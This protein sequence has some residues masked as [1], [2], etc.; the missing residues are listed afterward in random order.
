MPAVAA[1]VAGNSTSPLL[2]LLAALRLL[3][4][5][6]L[7]PLPRALLVARLL[8]LRSAKAQ[9]QLPPPPR[10]SPPPPPPPLP[11]SLTKLSYSYNATVRF[12]VLPQPLFI[13]E[14]ALLYCLDHGGQLASVQT[15][16]EHRFLAQALTALRSSDYPQSSHYFIGLHDHGA[17]TTTDRSAFSWVDGSPV[18]FSN[19]LDGQP[20]GKTSAAWRPY[21]GQCVA[22][23]SVSAEGPAEGQWAYD[24]LD[25]TADVHGAVCRV[26][27]PPAPAPPRAPSPPPMPPFVLPPPLFWLDAA[28]LLPDAAVEVWPDSSGNGFNATGYGASGPPSARRDARGRTYVDLVSED[29]NFLKI[30]QA[31]PVN[32]RNASGLL[33]NGFTIMAV[34]VLRGPKVGWKRLVDFAGTNCGGAA[35]GVI[36]V[37]PSPEMDQVGGVHL[38]RPYPVRTSHCCSAG[39]PWP[40]LQSPNSR[41]FFNCL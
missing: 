23:V 2:L 22:M 41:P 24:D 8:L 21:A 19:W 9:Q 34:T 25:C 40:V 18:T 6:L 30:D 13:W 29:S 7:Q 33:Y 11:A 20:D 1:A 32:V 4:L 15:A 31:I 12:D 27:T 36:F 39:T 10:L 38:A 28:P 17:S 14:A 35:C 37:S 16:D 5:L 3:L 26:V